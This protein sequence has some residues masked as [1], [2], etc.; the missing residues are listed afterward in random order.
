[1]AELPLSL[2]AKLLRALEAGGAYR[3]GGLSPRPIQARFVSATNRDLPAAIGQRR[4]R[5]G[6]VLPAGGFGATGAPAAGAPLRDLAAGRELRRQRGPGAGP[7]PGSSSP[8]RRA[9]GSPLAP[10][11]GNVRELRNA[12]E[13]AVL[14]ARDGVIGPEQLEGALAAPAAAARAAALDSPGARA[15]AHRRSH[16]SASRR[17]IVLEALAGSGGNQKLAAQRLGINRRTLARWLDQLAI[18]RPRIRET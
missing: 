6:P 1:M 11:P 10:W 9:S 4:L 8:R 2:Q 15:A 7:G 12:I 18:T 16:P 14:L 13:R 5:A 17:A 3:V